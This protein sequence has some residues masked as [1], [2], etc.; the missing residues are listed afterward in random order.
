MEQPP[1]AV[2]LETDPRRVS[3]RQTSGGDPLVRG[4]GGRRGRGESGD[5]K[6]LGAAINAARRGSA[7]GG[8]RLAELEG[9]T[10]ENFGKVSLTDDSFLGRYWTKN[11]ASHS[12]RCTRRS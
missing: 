12:R 10:R 4:G 2:V 9:R 7:T 8:A 3:K 5:L 1:V 11:I 6:E